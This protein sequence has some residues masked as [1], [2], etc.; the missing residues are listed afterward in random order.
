MGD[1]DVQRLAM[2][3]EGV[4]RVPVIIA[5]IPAGVLAQDDHEGR[6]EQDGDGRKASSLAEEQ[7]GR[8]LRR[9]GAGGRR[10]GRDSEPELGLAGGS[11]AWGGWAKGPATLLPAEQRG[12]SAFPHNGL[13]GAATRKRAQS[14]RPGE[15]PGRR[16][17]VNPVRLDNNIAQELQGAGPPG[18]RL[19]EAAGGDADR[20]GGR[21]PA[22]SGRPF[23]RSWSR[24]ATGASPTTSSGPWT[25]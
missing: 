23:L 19:G 17:S 15:V 13:R 14:G 24:A 2:I 7:A 16:R 11:S 4:R 1:D 10:H 5:E 9:G 8:S 21:S 6:P 3:E 18:M 12:N 22:P 25:G 20:D